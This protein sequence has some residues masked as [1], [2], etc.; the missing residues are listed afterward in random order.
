MSTQIPFVD[1]TIIDLLSPEKLREM[2]QIA[3]EYGLEYTPVIAVDS[4]IHCDK[5]KVT[6]FYHA[7]PNCVVVINPDN[8]VH[9]EWRK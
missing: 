9:A 6:R 8:S 5:E 4:G 3:F 1:P 7:I 2:R